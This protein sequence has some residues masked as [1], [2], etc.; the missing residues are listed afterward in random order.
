MS[1]I[2]SPELVLKQVLDLPAAVAGFYVQ[3]AVI[4]GINGMQENTMTI[5]LEDKIHE[6]KAIHQKYADRLAGAFFDYI[7]LASFGEARHAPSQAECYIPQ[8]CY[9]W[10]RDDEQQN[11]YVREE[12]YRHALQFDPYRFLPALATLFYDVKWRDAYGGKRWA[13][14]AQAGMMYKK[15][16]STVFVDHAVDLSHN[17][18]SMFSKNVLFQAYD[19]HSYIHML[20]IKRNSSILEDEKFLQTFIVAQNARPFLKLAAKLGLIPASMIYG[21]TYIPI[22]FPE[23]IKWGMLPIMES[24]ILPCKNNPLDEGFDENDDE[25]DDE[26]DDDKDN[27]DDEEKI[28]TIHDLTAR[29]SCIKPYLDDIQAKFKPMTQASMF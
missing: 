25:D 29:L 12:S 19:A 17:G 2:K 16:S 15:V 1:A 5:R 9:K 26:D 22:E 14:I 18:G 23:T 6:F 28:E 11:I 4:A 8:I 21:C 20:H 7:A 27:N 10:N 13:N 3:E 24:D